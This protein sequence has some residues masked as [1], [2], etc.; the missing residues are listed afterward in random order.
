MK[1]IRVDRQE[2][3]ALNSRNKPSGQE[4]EKK[5]EFQQKMVIYQLMQKRLEELQQQAMLIERKFVELETTKNTISDIEKTEKGRD[6]FFPLGSG[7]FV[8]GTASN[9]KSL[10]V[11]LGAGLVSVKD[12]RAAKD[13]L[14]KKGKEIENSGKSLEKEL[15]RTVEKLNEIALQLQEMAG[16]Q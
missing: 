5:A 11:E 1:N 10:M 8:K 9:D 15:K 2:K 7:V 3:T 6:L 12:T 13:F 4:E 16:Q 14:E